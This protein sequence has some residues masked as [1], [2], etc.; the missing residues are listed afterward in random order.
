[1]AT[2][3]EAVVLAWYLEDAARAELAVRSAD[4]LDAAPVYTAD[5]SAKRA[6]TAGGIFEPM[7]TYLTRDDPK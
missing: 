1:M 5:E 4:A 2:L 7:W 6:V 3:E